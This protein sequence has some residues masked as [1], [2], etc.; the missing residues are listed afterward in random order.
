VIPSAGACEDH[1]GPAVPWSLTRRAQ[2]ARKENNQE[3][4]EKERPYCLYHDVSRETGAIPMPFSSRGID[5]TAEVLEREGATPPPSEHGDYV[6]VM[7]KD[8]FDRRILLRSLRFDNR[9]KASIILCGADLPQWAILAHG[10]DPLAS[11]TG[12]WGLT[13]AKN[14]PVPTR[15]VFKYADPPED[16]N[17]FLCF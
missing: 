13:D 8:G 7:V 14:L 6:C 11:G 4:F 3:Q 10:Y 17:N 15:V 12:M 9:L 2:R 1:V 5:S 16:A